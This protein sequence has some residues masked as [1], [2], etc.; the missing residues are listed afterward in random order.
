MLHET[1]QIEKPKYSWLFVDKK[2]ISVYAVVHSEVAYQNW[3]KMSAKKKDI[4]QGNRIIF[5]EFRFLNSAKKVSY[6]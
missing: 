6:H 5:S 2:Q 3:G 4:N 1:K